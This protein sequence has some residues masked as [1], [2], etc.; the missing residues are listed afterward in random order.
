ML[1]GFQFHTHGETW[2]GL[3]HGKKE[4]FLYPPGFH[5]PINQ[6]QNWNPFIFHHNLTY[7]DYLE[8]VLCNGDMT[9]S[10]NEITNIQNISNCLENLEDIPDYFYSPISNSSKSK[11]DFTKKYKPIHIT[12]NAGDI[13][14]FPSGWSHMTFNSYP[15][16]NNTIN[17][18]NS[19]PNVVIGIGAQS[20]WDTT[21]REKQCFKILFSNN[22]NNGNNNESDKIEIEVG[23]EADKSNLLEIITTRKDNFNSLDYECLKSLG[24]IY[25]QRAFE[26]KQLISTTK[27]NNVDQI[28]EHT[29][30]R[31]NY[32]HLA[33]EF[34]Q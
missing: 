12:Q 7:Q 24:N 34:Y 20:I 23:I 10:N 26:I 6:Q 25:K 32:L 14:Y 16:D 18:E 31:C 15:N 2:I 9:T 27:Q 4:W 22:H 30:Q 8:K 19:S 29:I 17:I 5:L 28:N 1:I 13:L 33:V 3:I 11:Y 21:E